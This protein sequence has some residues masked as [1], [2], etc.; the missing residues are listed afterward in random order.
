M[1]FRWRNRRIG[2]NQRNL[3]IMLEQANSQEQNNHMQ[4]QDR[5]DNKKNRKK[6]THTKTFGSLT[7]FSLHVC[8]SSTATSVKT[9]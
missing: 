7:G 3:L 2:K 8:S 6:N 1:A 4:I 9:L 5:K